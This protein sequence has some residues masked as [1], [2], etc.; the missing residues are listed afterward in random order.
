[1]LRPVLLVAI[2]IGTSL[3]F[4]CSQKASQAPSFIRVGDQPH[5]LVLSLRSTASTRLVRRD[6][7]QMAVNR[8]WFLYETNNR[9]VLTKSL[10]DSFEIVVLNGFK[11]AALSAAERQT[12][13]SF[14]DRGGRVYPITAENELQ[15]LL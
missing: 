2:A 14:N 5:V 15:D 11:L 13:A 1:M 10:L 3:T 6:L 7:E 8:S 9:S 4:A 12:L